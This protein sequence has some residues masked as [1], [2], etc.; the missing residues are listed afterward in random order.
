MLLGVLSDVHA[1]LDALTDALAALDQ[2][3]CRVIVCAGDLVSYGAEPDRTVA[4]VAARAIPCARGNHDRW[5]ARDGRDL[6]GR[7]LSRQTALQLRALPER[8]ER[9]LEGV[10]V[11]VWH[12]RPGDDMAGIQADADAD[13][14]RRVAAES[15][16]EILIVGHVHSPMVIEVG[17]RL[18]VNPGALL[19]SKSDAFDVAT[20]GTFGVLELPARTFRV[21]RARGGA[22]IDPDARR[23]G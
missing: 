1:D 21:F 7:A 11:A 6:G 23:I 17:A 8:L 15:G 22:E 12:A 2:L 18:I 9:T 3:G 16:A 20:S 19:R 4:L 5:A 10:R 13:E 14:L